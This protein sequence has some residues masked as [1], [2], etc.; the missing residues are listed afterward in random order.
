MRLSRLI[1]LDR[2]ALTRREGRPEQFEH[3]SD[4]SAGKQNALGRQPDDGDDDVVDIEQ[5]RV[6]RASHTERV[7]RSRQRQ[8]QAPIGPAADQTSHAFG[9][10]LGKV[11]GDAGRGR[12]DD[13]GAHCR[14]VPFGSDMITPVGEEPRI[15]S[16][17]VA[18]PRARPTCGDAPTQHV[19]TWAGGDSNSR[20]EG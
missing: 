7:H 6:D 14:R 11:D 12:R 2:H 17:S 1:Q 10:A 13:G 8:Q 15:A 4:A 18:I 16:I 9:S 20:H 5:N 3:V 19:V